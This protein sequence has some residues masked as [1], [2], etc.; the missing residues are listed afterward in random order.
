MGHAKGHLPPGFGGREVGKLG[1]RPKGSQSKDTLS[2]KAVIRQAFE[3]SGG[4]P[5][6]IA[7]IKESDRN[8]ALFYTKIYTKL[9]PHEVVIPNGGSVI[10]KEI[11]RAIVDAGPPQRSLP[12]P[13]DAEFTPVKPNGHARG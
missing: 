7:W 8:R 2:V 4:V 6:M 1:G 9:L 5:A 12:K 13:I 10:V 11:I 3:L